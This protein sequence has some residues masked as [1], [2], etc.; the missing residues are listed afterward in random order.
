MVI[1]NIYIDK[2]NGRELILSSTG[3]LIF[4]RNC[5]VTTHVDWPN[6]NKTRLVTQ[7]FKEKNKQQVYV[8][9]T[10]NSIFTLKNHYDIL[11]IIII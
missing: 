4:R 8:V 1:V 3:E 5:C 9:C 7:H 10:A 6:E 2:T 11:I